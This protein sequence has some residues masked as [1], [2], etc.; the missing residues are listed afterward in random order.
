MKAS[1]KLHFLVPALAAAALMLAAPQ[2][3][4]SPAAEPDRGTQ[5]M[6][7]GLRAAFY[8]A[9]AEDA[10]ASYAINKDG[11]ATLA[12]QG[13]TA[14]FD[15]HGAHFTGAAPLSLHLVAFGRSD[16]L[17]PVSA[18]K[19]T[20]HGNEV[21][22]AHGNLTEWWRVLPVGFEQGFTI[23]ERPAGQ[24]DLILALS[25]TRRP[26]ETPA[27]RSKI[28]P[29]QGRGKTSHRMPAS[30]GM[31][32]GKGGHAIAW[33]EL[34]YGKL[35]VTDAEGKVVPASLKIAS[36]LAPTEAGERV[37]IAVNDLHAVYPLTVD[38][39]VWIEQQV[40]ASDGAAGDFFGISVAL[41]GATALVG[42]YAAVV[43]GNADQGAVY[44]FSKSGG[45]WS[46]AQKLTAS[47]GAADDLFG[48]SVALD[49]ATALVGA[50]FADV[51]GNNAQGAAY[52]FTETNGTWT[53]SQKLTASDGTENDAFGISV[54]LDGTTALVGASGAGFST[55]AVYV[56]VN[57]G[58]TWSETHK[59]TASDGVFNDRF[60]ASIAL[61]G[62]VVLVG[63]R[64]A[65]IGGNAEQGAAYVFTESG[66]VWSESAKLTASDGAAGDL[67]GISVALDGTTAFVGAAYADLGG[68]PDQGAAYVFTESG[69]AWSETQ[70]LTASGGAADN[71][72]GTSTALDGAT[73]IVGNFAGSAYVFTESNGTWTQSRELTVAVTFDSSLALDGASVLIGAS[74]DIGGQGAAYF[75]GRSDLDLAMSAPA[76]VES[77]EQYVSEAIVTNSSAAD[78]AAISAEVPVPSGTSF[79]SANATQGSCS[80]AAGVVT[81]DFGAIGGNAGTATANVTFTASGSVGDTI[82]NTASVI[83][84]TPAL[85]AS[86]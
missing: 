70:K 36:Q 67:F 28:K 50:F 57:S 54:G 41:D 19:P 55:G 17:A 30:A 8:R 22:Y 62:T 78:S 4:A 16:D 6:P 42:A 2:A 74:F 44:V 51:G 14:C 33:G 40:T 10:G 47:D 75:Y 46:E 86:A 20:I 52:V 15:R 29:T 56:F 66:G 34:R 12:K 38:P 1:S 25:T 63:A 32:Q 9:L 31:T 65:T 80:E 64:N 24:G 85:T 71:K 37:L 3:P 79:V 23:A 5:A 83:L 13:L 73:A 61:D 53:Q 81:C 76:E 60:G 48:V 43:G 11:C 39:L 84:A 35:V 26:G 7:A 18:V 77:G 58:G 69:G 27:P 68:N 21:R 59:L 49:G 82:T 72:F 45:V